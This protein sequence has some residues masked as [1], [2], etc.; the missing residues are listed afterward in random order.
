M[1]K[2]QEAKVVKWLIPVVCLMVMGQAKGA[3]AHGVEIQYQS[4]QALN[5]QANYD[6]GEPMKNAQVTIYAP[7][8]DD[9]WLTGKTDEKGQFTFTPDTSRPG[10][11]EVK[12]RSAGHGAIL[13]I[14]VE[15]NQVGGAIVQG[16]TG[17]TSLQ[18]G[19]MTLSVIWGL[20]GTAL[21]FSRRK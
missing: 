8:K 5:I 20:V 2:C 10:S 19:I 11:W 7:G 6:T 18:Q 17:Y 15:S 16:S 12:V 21:F 9:P 1:W 4:T 3:I 14:P 13:A